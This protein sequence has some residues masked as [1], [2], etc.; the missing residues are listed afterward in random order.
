MAEWMDRPHWEIAGGPE[1]RILQERA[2][3]GPS[4][5]AGGYGRLPR[6]SRF[7]PSPGRRA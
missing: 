7:E 1:L 4:P 3:K 2:V 5:M 6:A